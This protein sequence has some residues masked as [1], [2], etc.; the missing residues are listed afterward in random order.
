MRCVYPGTIEC[1][2]GLN[3]CLVQR[4]HRFWPEDTAE[5]SE[6]NQQNHSCPALLPAGHLPLLPHSQSH[7]DTFHP[8]QSFLCPQGE[9]AGVS[10]LGP[11]PGIW[12][13]LY[14]LCTKR[15]LTIKIFESFISEWWR[16]QSNSRSL[17]SAH[18]S[19]CKNGQHKDLIPK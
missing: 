19:Y 17:C 12:S 10:G 8:S 6:C 16:E 11:S 2:H 5:H 14:A 3:H 1:H 13:Q 18:W 15:K 9:G 4:Q 7:E